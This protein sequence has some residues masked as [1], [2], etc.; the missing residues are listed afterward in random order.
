M[1]RAHLW[2]IPALIGIFSFTLSASLFSERRR[3]DRLVEGL[4]TIP[5]H[6]GGWEYETDSPLPP[7]TL[8]RLLPSEYISRVYRK[9][10]TQLG[11][12]VAYYAEQRTGESMHSPKHCLPG[13]GWEIWRYGSIV[14]PVNGGIP[15]NNYSIQKSG[16]RATVIYWY[17]SRDRVIASEFLGKIL[18]VHDA[19]RTGQTAG[20]FVRIVLPDDPTAFNEG[21]SF[22]AATL[23][24]MQRCFGQLRS[25][26][27]ESEVRC[28]GGRCPAERLMNSTLSSSLTRPDLFPAQ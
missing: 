7:E 17:Q 28:S 2:L 11:L 24:E 15:V 20:A 25:S 9:G 16:V 23:R 12:Y 18:L 1:P 27:I 19:L 10:K 4:Q 13:S 8:R 21:V 26:S 3:P 5:F 6:L 14:L 22:A